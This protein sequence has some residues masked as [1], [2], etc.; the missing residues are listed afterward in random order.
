MAECIITIGN[1]G[2][3]KSLLA[4]KFA[5]KDFVVCNM[6]ELQQMIAG[7]EYG[8]YDSKKKEV[9]RKAEEEVIKSALKSGLSVF[10]DRTNMDKKRRQRFINLAKKYTDQIVC[11]NF[12]QGNRECLARR[13]KNPHGIPIET[14]E[15][16]F[17]SMSDAYEEPVMEEGFSEIITAPERYRF[18]AFDFDGAIVRNKFPEIGEILDGTVQKMN[19]IWKVLSNII[20]IWTSRSG[21]Y[22]NQMRHFLIK[23]KIPFDFI[24][25]NPIF[26]TGSRK[27]FAH[28]Y[29]DDRM[30]ERNF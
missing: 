22:E 21:N 9:Y 14:W 15:K 11:Y 5:A 8:R 25:E 7:G 17:S 30:V 19:Q 18:Y 24:N 13:L 2:S 26:D 28:E 6:D 12:G 1:I 10:I 23:N 3:G 20:I 4:S 27:I 16:V 29:F